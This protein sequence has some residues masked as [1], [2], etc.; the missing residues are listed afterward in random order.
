VKNG[1]YALYLYGSGTLLLFFLMYV[2]LYAFFFFRLL[3]SPPTP[4]IFNPAMVDMCP[5]SRSLLLNRLPSP[6]FHASF[7]FSRLSFYPFFSPWLKLFV[8]FPEI[9]TPFT[10]FPAYLSPT[11]FEHPPVLQGLF[12]APPFILRE[13]T[14]SRPSFFPTPPP[15]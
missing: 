11:N 1:S 13:V 6:K 14:P 3:A 15:C 12:L 5:F 2:A 8:A 10:L 7:F 4:P 9:Y